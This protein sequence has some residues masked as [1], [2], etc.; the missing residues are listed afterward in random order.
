MRLLEEL[1]NVSSPSG[2]ENDMQLFILQRLESLGVDYTID[3]VGNIYATKGKARTYPCV[4]AHMDEVHSRHS[5]DFRVVTVKNRLY[6][7][8][9]AVA[10]PVSERMTKTEFG[11]A[12]NVCNDSRRL[13]AS[14]LSARSAVVSAATRR[15]WRFSTIADS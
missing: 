8:S 4:V 10:L 1:Y 6:S 9:R 2:E 15:R 12:S 13:N 11:Y 5:A 14:F 7:D 3:A